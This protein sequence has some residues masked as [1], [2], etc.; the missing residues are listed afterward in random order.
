L[1]EKLTFSEKNLLI[2][3]MNNIL[4]K[5]KTVGIACGVCK[6]DFNLFPIQSWISFKAMIYTSIHWLSINTICSIR[7]EAIENIELPATSIH[8]N[9]YYLFSS[10]VDF[11]NILR[12]T[13]GSKVLRRAILYLHF[14]FVNFF[15]K[16]RSFTMLVKWKKRANFAR[17]VFICFPILD[18]C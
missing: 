3:I 14:V 5:F 1:K 6:H 9:C 17:F 18:R 2:I 13:F 11:I 12:A 4:D 8:W 10:V 15:Y 16:W 7:S